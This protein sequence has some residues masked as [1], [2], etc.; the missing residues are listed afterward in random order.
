M[1]NIHSTYVLELRAL[2]NSNDSRNY[3]YTNWIELLTCHITW[4]FWGLRQHS[5][6][7]QLIS[8]MALCGM[9]MWPTGKLCSAVQL[10]GVYS[11]D[12]SNPISQQSDR[13]AGLGWRE[14]SHTIIVLSGQ[15]RLWPVVLI[16]NACVVGSK[17]FLFSQAVK[18]LRQNRHHPLLLFQSF[19][20]IYPPSTVSMIPQTADSN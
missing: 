8:R 6:T 2:T 13:S 5:V 17:S 7:T 4:A 15:M 18:I 14:L 11:E 19:I 1:I 16:A 12:S 10:H 20:S 9:F 3:I